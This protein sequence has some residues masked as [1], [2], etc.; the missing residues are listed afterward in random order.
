MAT[1]RIG[2]LASIIES[3]TAE[4]DGYLSSRGLP[5]PSFEDAAPKFLEE[6]PVAACRQAILEATDEL[7]SLMLGPFEIFQDPDVCF[8][9]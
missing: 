5:T 9:L 7:H 2:E 3:N 8:P 6:K 1:T 4:L